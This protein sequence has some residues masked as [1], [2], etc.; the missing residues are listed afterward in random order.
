MLKLLLWSRYVRKRKIVLLSVAALALS[1]ALLIV[2]ASLFTGFIGAVETSATEVLGD[3]VL[4][5]PIKFSH[6]GTLIRDLE[7]S[8]SVEVATAVMMTKGLLYLGKGNVRAVQ[9]FGVEPE[10]FFKVVHFKE[11]LVT[12][13][14][15]DYGLASPEPADMRGLVSIGVVA[16]PNEL[17]DQYDD[18]SIRHMVGENKILFCGTM[19]AN[20]SQT[21]TGSTRFNRRNIYFNIADVVRSGH[22]FFDRESVFLP[23]DRLYRELY[24]TDTPSRVQRIQI[25]LT[26]HAD[27]DRAI[28]DIEAIWKGFAQDQQLGVYALTSTSIDTAKDLQARYM[29]EIRKQMGMLLVIFGI[30]DVGVIALIF[31]IFYMIVKLKQ[32]DI[33]I[34][35]SCGGASSSIAAIFLGFGAFVGL[36]GSLFGILLGWWFTKNINTIEGWVAQTFNLNLWDSSL[37]VFEHIPSDMDWFSVLNIVLLA[38]GAACLGALI[39]AVVAARTRPVNILRYE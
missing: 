35:K 1:V 2:V 4:S 8:E 12:P 11:A 3:V 17:T 19:D 9:V 34:I 5:C 36:L 23:L 29:Q 38:I 6:Y 25:R 30:V 13:V 28:D 32:K 21:Q 33:G 18:E 24:L 14:N 37:Y 31:C 7:Q 10:R 16:D 39:P 27:I 15:G 22:Y 20:P 26:A